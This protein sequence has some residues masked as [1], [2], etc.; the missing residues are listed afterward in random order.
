VVRQNSETLWVEGL[1]V[2]YLCAVSVAGLS[3]MVARDNPFAIRGNYHVVPPQQLD[4]EALL[5]SNSITVLAFVAVNLFLY[6]LLVC[7][8]VFVFRHC[9]SLRQPPGVKG[10]PRVA[11]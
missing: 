7:H 3:P 9:E 4:W 5:P 8:Q 6:S 11:H 2:V 1:L 10:R